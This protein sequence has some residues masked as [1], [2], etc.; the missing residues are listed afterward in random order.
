MG[1]IYKAFVK[2]I[3]TVQEEYAYYIPKYK[4]S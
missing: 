1:D 4:R 3:F 2:R